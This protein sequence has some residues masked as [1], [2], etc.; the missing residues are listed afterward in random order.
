M[1]GIEEI[2]F[3]LILASLLGSI[4]GIEREINKRP[5]GLR[6]HVLVTLGATLITI[7]S[8]SG[9]VKTGYGDPYRLAAQV[10]SGIGFLGAGTIMQRE[11][12][13]DGLTTAASL[14][15]TAGIG[16]G[17][18]T[19]YYLASVTTAVMVLIVL[20]SLGIYEDITISRKYSIVKLQLLNNPDIIESASKYLEQCNINIKGVFFPDEQKAQDD[21]IDISY[22]VSIPK[23]CDRTILV[24]DLMSCAGIRKVEILRYGGEKQ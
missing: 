16:M 11:D 14:W 10:V 19:G 20:M 22:K 18:G 7:V 4:I 1:L 12:E 9:A 6:T 24:D 5:A 23:R 15:V 2:I 3:K 13:V 17:I 8:I 21:F